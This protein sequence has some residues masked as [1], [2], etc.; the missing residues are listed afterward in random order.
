M[1]S[2]NFEGKCSIELVS[3]P[4]LEPSLKLCHQRST[5]RTSKMGPQLANNKARKLNNPQKKVAF[6]IM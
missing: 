5:N 6:A 2:M 3:L 1:F 4:K